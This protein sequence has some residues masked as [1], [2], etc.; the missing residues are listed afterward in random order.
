MGTAAYGTLRGLGPVEAVRHTLEPSATLTYQPAFEGLTFVDTGGVRRNRYPGVSASESRFL[1]L[2]LNQRFQA[3]VRSGDAVRRVDVLN[4]RLDSAYDLVAAEN[5]ARAWSDISS[6][7]DLNRVLGVDLR[8]NSS[9]DPYAGARFLTFQLTGSFTLRGSLPGAEGDVP[10]AETP[11]DGTVGEDLDEDWAEAGADLTSRTR[12]PSGERRMGAGGGWNLGLTLS[13][14]GARDALDD[15]ETT[16]SVNASGSLQ[17]TRN[18][19]VQYTGRWDLEKGEQLGETITL[20]RDLHCWE[21]EFVRSRLTDDTAFY[22]KINVKQMP[23]VKYQQGE[24]V[25]TGFSD[26][27]RIIP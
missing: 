10:P 26:L 20:K 23:D 15:L 6:E 3:K 7:V 13:H 14:A 19:S 27:E 22:F 18:W 21:A 4:W 17:I 11:E 9:H 25:A 12:D 1:S 16:T 2:S 24:G 8:F 5:G